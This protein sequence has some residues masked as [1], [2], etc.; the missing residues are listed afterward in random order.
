MAM[1]FGVATS[2][3]DKQKPD[4]FGALLNDPFPLFTQLRTRGAVMPMPFPTGE[5]Q[6]AWMVTR[7]EEAFQ[8][9]KDS[10][11][12]T[13]N[14]TTMQGRARVQSR[15]EGRE[16]F[17]G[18]GNSMLSVDG[19]DHKR[20]RSLVSKVFTPKYIQDLRPNIQKIADT[21]IDR[22]VDQGAMEL[23]ADFA[24]PLPINVISDMLGV[25]HKSWDILRDGSRAIIDGGSMA[26]DEQVFAEARRKMK[27]YNDYIRY[28]VAEKRRNPANDLIS[29]LVQIEEEGDRLNETELLSMIALLILAGHETTSNLIGTGMLALFDY[30]EQM[31]ILKADLSLVPTAIEELLRF[32]GPV[33]VPAPRVATQDLELGG[34]R[35]SRGDIV[36]PI[37]TSA[38]RDESH[39]T[40]AD[41]LDLARKINRHL[42]FGYGIH[43]CLGAPLARLEGDIAFTTLLRRLPNIR[44][45]MPREEIAWHGAL[46]V[47]GLTRLPVVF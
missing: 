26:Q 44:L 29:Q 42:A 43:V 33:L 39:F 8:V 47:R 37:L 1:Q 3:A 2:M 12:F 40:N 36:M 35:I 46:N 6:K 23:I 19:L 15:Q 45:N 10:E 18:L 24:F 5:D 32:A 9:L 14:A 22:V 27:S 11:R 16:D 21:L 7:L 20:L 41:D 4:F 38:N 13:V 31:A 25:P 34:Q 30:P 17:V 28:L